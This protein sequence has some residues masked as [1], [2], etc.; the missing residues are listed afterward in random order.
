PA[1]GGIELQLSVKGRP[2]DARRVTVPPGDGL[3]P[4]LW[5]YLRSLKIDR[6]RFSLFNET[7]GR[8]VDPSWPL[9]QAG[10]SAGDSLVIGDDGDFPDP[11]VE[12]RQLL[13]GIVDTRAWPIAEEVG[14]AVL[15]TRGRLA[16]TSLEHRTA[17]REAGMPPD[18]AQVLWE[19]KPHR[20]RTIE[21]YGILLKLAKGSPAVSGSAVRKLAELRDL[22]GLTREEHLAQAATLGLDAALAERL[23]E[24]AAPV[25]AGYGEYGAALQAAVAAGFSQDSLVVLNRLAQKYSIGREAHR[26]LAV[27]AGVVQELVD[28]CFEDQPGMPVGRRFYVRELLALARA[29]P[30]EPQALQRLKEVREKYAVRKGEH[31]RHCRDWGIAEPDAESLW[32]LEPPTRHGTLHWVMCGV[33]FVATAVLAYPDGR[34]TLWS[35]GRSL[36]AA[37]R[38]TGPAEEPAFDARG[39][40]PLG[41]DRQG[42]DRDGF[43]RQGYDRQG[44]GRD[45][46]NRAGFNRAGYDRKGFNKNGFDRDGFDRHGFGRDGFNREGYDRDGFDRAGFNRRGLDR[47]GYNHEGRDKDG[48]DRR[49][50]DK[51]GFHRDGFNREGYDGEGYDRK[52]FNKAGLDRKGLGRDGLDKDGYGKDGFNRDGYDKQGYDRDG[53]DKD[54]FKRDGFNREGRDRRGL[55]R[56]RQDSSGFDQHGFDPE[57]FDRQGYNRE[58]RDRRGFD[59][60]GYD[61]SGHD[62]LGYAKDG[63]DKNGRDRWGRDRR[64]L[65]RD[66]FG[67]DGFGP[68]GYNRQGYDRSGFDRRGRNREGIDRDGYDPEGFDPEGRSRDGKDLLPADVTTLESESGEWTLRVG[69]SPGVVYRKGAR[70]PPHG[71]I[72]ERIGGN[73][74]VFRYGPRVYSRRVQK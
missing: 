49:G 56:N 46:F 35:A 22:L 18:D 47:Q 43:N 66:G 36:V 65:D 67:K 41:Y 2:S 44:Y 73:V 17:A 1:P 62:R 40:D 3:E 19:W 32:R 53:Y 27:Q 15:D 21:E 50:W 29:H 9:D 8:R 54:G 63:F 23:L 7:R 16:V 39:F 6:E 12:Y 24:G 13:R 34:T 72:L 57:G 45:G 74:A 51:S 71:V 61:K 26:T 59:R 10:L 69:R 30:P 5:E 58:G 52:G 60:A 4:H 38:P 28:A 31:M 55:D 64:G 42:F 70:V 68:D 11:L 14:L 33:I 25:P 37:F 20:E 48:F